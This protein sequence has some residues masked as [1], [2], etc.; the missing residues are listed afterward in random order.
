MRHTRSGIVFLL[1]ALVVV[2]CGGQTGKSATPSPTHLPP[3]PTLPPAG[4]VSATISG[5]GALTLPGDRYGLAAD[6]TAVWV[7]NPE[8]NTVIRIDPTTNKVVTTIPVGHGGGDVALGPDAV[9]VL[10]QEEQTISRIDPQT[11]TV[12]ATITLPV[13]SEMLTVSPG[14]VWVGSS[15][16]NTVTRINPQ[17]NQIVATLP[18]A[19]GPTGLSFGAGSLWVCNHLGGS[20]GLTRLN[21]ATNQIQAQI[22]V[23]NDQ[24][25]EC[26]QVVAIQN[27]IWVVLAVLA[28]YQEHDNLLERISSATN[29]IMATV[30]LPAD[31]AGFIADETSVWAFDYY[32]GLFRVDPQTNQVAGGLS[33]AGGAG[34]ALGASSVWFA[35]GKTGTLLRITPAA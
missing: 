14:A 5:V 10:N 3:A 26:G 13:P 23:G 30:L 1:G 20:Q 27:T 2:A 24:G 9:W 15:E 29:Q 35:D 32:H 12:V 11:N 17:T 18:T 22:D 6:E 16:K 8:T 33:L 21:S 7:H 28:N 4:I 25:Y 34:V 19:P 31:V